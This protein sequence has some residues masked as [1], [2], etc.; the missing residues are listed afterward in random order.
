MDDLPEPVTNLLLYNGIFI[1]QYCLLESR[2]TIFFMSDDAL[3][4]RGITVQRQM[5]IQRL[6][7]PVQRRSAIVS[8]L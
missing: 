4:H 7:Y 5:V 6:S 8:N 3:L 2:V 1:R